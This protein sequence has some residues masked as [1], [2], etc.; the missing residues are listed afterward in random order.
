LGIIS[1]LVPIPRD[2]IIQ[3][4]SKRGWLNSARHKLILALVNFPDLDQASEWP[5]L[6]LSEYQLVRVCP[7][8]LLSL[9][10]RSLI[11]L[12]D[13]TNGACDHDL[14]DLSDDLANDYGT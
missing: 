3:R 5:R 7:R 11:T 6:G 8:S 14:F 4:S 12:S 13:G 2:H 9:L 1:H 10:T